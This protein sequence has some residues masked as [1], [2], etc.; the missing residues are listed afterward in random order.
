MLIVSVNN[1]AKSFGAQTLFT[2]L[3][4]GLFEGQKV[5]LLG[6]NGAGKSTLLK[7]LA[8]IET[9]DTGE[10]VH[11]KGIKVHYVEQTPSWKPEMSILDIFT[12]RYGSQLDELWIEI[13]EEWERFEFEKNGYN[14]DTLFGSLSGGWKKRLQLMLELVI[15]P[16]LLLLDEPTNH[17]DLES[18]L[19]LEEFL[20]K[21]SFA[22]LLISHDRLFI[23]NIT[24]RIL[25]LNSRF[26]KGLLT[27][28]GDYSSYLEKRDLIISGQMSEQA[29]VANTFRREVEWLRRGAKA[30]QTKQKARIER[31][32][33]IGDR[34][35]D[36][37]EKNQ[38]RLVNIDFGTSEKR[39]NKLL[40]TKH[41][42]KSFGDRTLFTNVDMLIS[43]KT[44]LAL[45]GKNGCG[46]ST[47]IKC[48]LELEKPTSGEVTSYEKLDYTY[49]EQYKDQLDLNKTVLQNIC[50]EGDYVH[51]QGTFVHAR[52]Y[53]ERFNFYRHKYDLPVAR[54]SGGEQARLR[55]AQVLL[56][57]V[58]V[59]IL[60]E[61][62]N[63]LDIETLDVLV[64]SLKNF[65]GAI[66]LVTHDRFFIDQLCDQILY[67]DGEGGTEKFAELEQWEEFIEDRKVEKVESAQQKNNTASVKANKK[68]SNKDKYEF[69][70][71]EARIAEKEDELKKLQTLLENP[72]Q[73]G[74]P[75]KMNK[76][77]GDLSKV[78][79]DLDQ[80]YTRWSELE[81]IMKP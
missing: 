63:D 79:S 8:K 11:K 40:E 69:E 68:V 56:K 32:G 49:Y 74:D 47:F 70:N 34:L 66:I 65:Q 42:T 46:K 1:L 25:E 18:I 52:S 30:R 37:K 20:N 33:E 22:V 75:K 13:Q 6:P 44:R 3:S 54:L 12:K 31:S 21:Q 53:L 41:L 36:L 4:F 9:Q 23:Q 17:L 60:D 39:A 7:I 16:D 72:S 73:I 15:K 71:M 26:D 62:T 45:L 51:F 5:A 29:R 35:D 59:L 2:K 58:Q 50:P 24:N 57:Q 14:F 28:E 43:K 27:H 78:Q 48:L 38:K 64:E 61:P 81:E 76:V 19:W 55:L 80:L 67:F 10:M 77:M